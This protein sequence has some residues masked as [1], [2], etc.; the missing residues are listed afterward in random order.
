MV[1]RWYLDQIYVYKTCLKLSGYQ[2]NSAGCTTVSVKK[3]GGWTSSW[4]DAKILGG[5][6]PASA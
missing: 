2:T 4:K 1:V 6:E 3:R 5:W